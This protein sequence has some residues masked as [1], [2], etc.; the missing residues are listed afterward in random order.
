MKKKIFIIGM[1]A[2]VLFSGCS[3][4]GQV[5]STAEYIGIDAAKEAALTEAGLTDAVFTLS[6]LDSKDGIFYYDVRFSDVE[7]DTEYRYA[8]DAMTGVVI[9]EEIKGADAEASETESTETGA[10]VTTAAA[11]TTGINAV[12]TV[13][14]ATSRRRSDTST[15]SGDSSYIGEEAAKEAALSHAGLESTDV[16]SMRVKRE[17][18]DGR[19]IYDVEFYTNSGGEYDYKIDAMSGDV[20]SYD[21]ELDDYHLWQSGTGSYTGG[22]EL[23]SETD[24]KAIV[25]ERVPGAADA[26]IRLKLDRDD[27]RLEYEGELYYDGMKYEFTIDAYSGEVTEWEAKRR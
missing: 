3:Y 2:L 21:Y 20:L 11:N 18:D 27:G 10:E 22:E 16:L 17:R 1:S 5:R 25:K 7:G 9:E 24:A 15:E 19:M 8:I 13:S 26:D 12:Q 6:G 14:S 23:I 4:T